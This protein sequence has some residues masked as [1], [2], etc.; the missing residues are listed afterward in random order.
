MRMPLHAHTRHAHMGRY[1]AYTHVLP[2]ARA[3]AV[4]LTCTG[5]HAHATHARVCTR[6]LMPLLARKM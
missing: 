2:H 5:I 1:N 3:R 6:T 4:T